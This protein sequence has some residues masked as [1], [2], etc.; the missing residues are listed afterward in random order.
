[1]QLRAGGFWPGYLQR[2]KHSPDLLVIGG[3]SNRGDAEAVRLVIKQ[4]RARK[5]DTE[6]LLL[7]PLFGALRDE[8]IRTFTHEIDTSPYCP[9]PA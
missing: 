8:R 9:V 4:V 7:T 1:M 5:P 2:L 3:I 6:V